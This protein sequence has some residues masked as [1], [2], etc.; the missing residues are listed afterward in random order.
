MKICRDCL[1]CGL[2][3]QRYMNQ[4]TLDSGRGKY[5]SVTCAAKAVTG[6]K[7]S[8]E[9]RAKISGPKPHRRKL[10]I[11]LMCPVCGTEFHDCP[12]HVAAG[13]RYCSRRCTGIAKRG[14]D[15]LSEE[16][17]RAEAAFLARKNEETD[18]HKLRRKIQ[19][20]EAWRKKVFNRDGYQCGFCG[21]V[22]G[23]LESDH[24]LPASLYP[25]KGL[26]PDNGQTLCKDCHKKKTALDRIWYDNF[27]TKL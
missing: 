21:K 17:R 19:A 16:G 6:R 24:I 26:D 18:Q 15:L 5:C 4:E 13:R 1:V 20:L 11:W 3:F 9:S 25:E 22:G 10:H 23:D 14:I 7:W 2:P 12:G 8:E 27:R